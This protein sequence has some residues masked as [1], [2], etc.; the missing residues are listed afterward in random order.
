MEISV[1]IPTYYRPWDLA[2]LFES[3]LRQT[4]KP[5]EVIVVDDTPTNVIKEVYETYYEKFKR[6]GIELFYVR[7]YKKPSLT[8]ARNIGI[9]MVKG[10]IILFLDN[11]IILYP[12][13][14]EKILEMFK[15][16]PNALGAQG[17]IIP[18]NIP[19]KGKDLLKYFALNNLRKLFSLWHFTSNSCGPFN[20][21]M[22]L[23]EISNCERLSGSNMSF[24]RVV[25][26]EFKF[27]EN[28]LRYSYLED[29]LFT[30]PIQEKYPNSL[31]ITPHARCI[32]KASEEG[33]MKASILE[34]P[35]LRVCRK[36][37]LVKLFGMKGLLIFGW[38]IL[39]LLVLGVLRKIGNFIKF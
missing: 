35:Y 1:I 15:K 18:K 11:D 23:N 16:Y 21:P 26:E 9:S 6:L 31:Y 3:L 25:F 7:N 37:A 19:L 28:L 12:D 33:R 17:W 29:L 8:I 38:Q 39:G 27:D 10:E 4:I 13:Y 5:L 14:I 36:Y 32:H 2:E 24:R 34:Y 22:I 20:Y 30:Y